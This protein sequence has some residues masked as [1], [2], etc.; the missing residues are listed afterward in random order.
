MGDLTLLPHLLFNHL[1]ISAWTPGY[2]LDTLSSIR[3]TLLFKLFE[4]WSLG[5]FSAA[6]LSLCHTSNNVWRVPTGFGS[7]CFEESLINGFFT[8]VR[9]GQRAP[10]SGVNGLAVLTLS[11]AWAPS[12]PWP[13]ISFCFGRPQ[14]HF[15][16]P[17][18]NVNSDSVSSPPDEFLSQCTFTVTNGCRSLWR[19]LG[20]RLTVCVCTH[21]TELFCKGAEHLGTCICSWF[22]SWNWARGHDLQLCWIKLGLWLSDLGFWFSG[23]FVFFLRAG[24]T[25]VD[26]SSVSF[27]KKAWSL[28]HH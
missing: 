11:R 5:A 7:N 25:A 9:S 1:F 22:R 16:S 6:P 12:S 15:E 17:W 8:K 26:C 4:L 18:I 21:G 28:S 23:G 3:T 27:L 19:R 20:G 14:W 13:G 10:H 24:T 2:L